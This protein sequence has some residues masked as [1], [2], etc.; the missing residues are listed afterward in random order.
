MTT[1]AIQD[2]E[3]GSH[4]STAGVRSCTTTLEIN[5]EVS[6]NFEN[7]STSRTSYSVS[8]I[9]PKNTPPYH[10]DTCSTIFIEALLVIA[11]NW[12]QPRCPSM[13]EWIKKM[14]FIY[15]MEYSS[16]IKNKDITKFVNKWMKLEKC[17]SQWDNPDPK[18]Y[19]W[20]VLTYKW[21][22]VIKYRITNHVSVL[23]LKETKQQGE[24]NQ[25]CLSLT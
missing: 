12:K 7:S 10:K 4:S 23:K 2:V 1:H 18:G 14:W 24:T 22:L 16:T 5:L 3:Q 19:A 20:Y 13:E 17:Y 8:G 9:C 15:T 25:A 11:R 21:I 6:Q